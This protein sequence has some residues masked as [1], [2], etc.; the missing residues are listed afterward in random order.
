MQ[1]GRILFHAPASEREPIIQHLW[2]LAAPKADKTLFPK[3]DNI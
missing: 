1:E 2:G 3:L